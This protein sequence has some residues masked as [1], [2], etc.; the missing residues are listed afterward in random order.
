[1]NSITLVG[2][3]GRD[4]E[5]KSTSTGK[6]YA[7]FSVAVPKRI[8]P[9]NG[10]PDADWFNVKVWGKTAD[11]VTGYLAKGSLVSVSGRM[12][13][14]KYTGKDGASRE[15]W[16]VAADQVN[17]LDKKTDGGNKPNTT[18][19]TGGNGPLDFDPFAED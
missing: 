5:L 1:M 10:D 3:I 18:Q 9:T 13:S 16:E 11:Y 15:I 6:S 7:V 12:E 17:G 8:K 4:V 14:R 19:S 2:R